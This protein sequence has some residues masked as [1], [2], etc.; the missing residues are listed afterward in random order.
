MSILVLKNVRIRLWEDRMKRI[1]LA[2]LTVVFLTIVLI[3][4][5][6]SERYLPTEWNFDYQRTYEGNT[7]AYEYNFRR[8]IFGVLVYSQ[9]E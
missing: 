5:I 6:A 7:T 2:M 3:N 9:S 4:I 1:T 8:T